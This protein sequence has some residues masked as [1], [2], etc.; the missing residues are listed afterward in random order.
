MRLVTPKQVRVQ[1]HWDLL[2][3]AQ[4]AT[5]PDRSPSPTN[6]RKSLDLQETFSQA[7]EAVQWS[8]QSHLFL[9]FVCFVAISLLRQ[10]IQTCEKYAGGEFQQN[11][12]LTISKVVLGGIVVAVFGTGIRFTGS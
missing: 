9:L 7:S 6:K 4:A 8:K 11:P 5:T 1:H 10:S 12:S 2:Q 3:L